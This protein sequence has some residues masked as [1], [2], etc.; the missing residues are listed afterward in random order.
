MKSLNNKTVNPIIR[1]ILA[2]IAGWI[3]GSIINGGIISIYPSVVP[4]PKEIIPGDMQSLV[5]NVHLLELPHLL[6]V[7]LAHALGAL[8]GAFAAVKIGVSHHKTLALVIGG[9]F[10]LGGIAVNAML[11]FTPMWFS[12]TDI[13]LAYLP[14]AL[15]GLYLAKR[16]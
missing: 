3:V 6:F 8:F 14:M 12:V 11:N 2:V 9:L 10:L 16:K 5:N 13:L 1:N 7:F 4:L 15:I